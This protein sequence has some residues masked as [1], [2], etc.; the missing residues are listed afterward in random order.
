MLRRGRLAILLSAVL[1]VGLLA[2]GCGGKQAP[3]GTPGGGAGGGTT[4]TATEFSFEPK[5][6][7]VKAG[8]EVTLTL[9]NAGTQAHDLVIENI[10]AEVNGQQQNEVRTELVQAGS[11]ASVTFKPLQPGT[12]TIYCSVPG[13]REAGMEAKLIVE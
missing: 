7:R 9:K 8:Q 4:L 10:S 11:Q 5:E 2:A 1:V 13:H 12:Y 6:I 3:Q